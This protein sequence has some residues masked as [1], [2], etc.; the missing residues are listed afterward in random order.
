MLLHID[1][2]TDTIE[3][4]ILRWRAR[5]S[6]PHLILGALS[7]RPTSGYD[8]DKRF[9]TSVNHFWSTDR[10]QIYRALQKLRD[11]GLVEDE[12]IVQ[13]DYPNKKVYHITQAGTAELAR[14]LRMPLTIDNAPMRDG[15]L[16]QLFFGIH[17]DPS[18]TIA[19]M[20]VYL[21]EAEVARD[22]LVAIRNEVFGEG[23]VRSSD[24]NAALRLATLE[25]GISMRSTGVEWLR[26]LVTE[27]E[28]DL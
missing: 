14:W 17:G 26:R 13:H 5:V 8:L 7:D 4:H 19:V 16:G 2:G 6:L 28:E 25:Y 27:L 11:A 15:W 10:S 1:A 21:S 23:D 24:R 12:Q 20:R 22:R 9:Q 18:E 3:A